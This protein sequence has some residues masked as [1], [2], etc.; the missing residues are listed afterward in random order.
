MHNQKCDHKDIEEIAARIAY[1][2]EERRIDYT[3]FS[4][5]SMKALGDKTAPNSDLTFKGDVAL[6][7]RAFQYVHVSSLVWAKKYLDEETFKEFV[8]A[9]GGML[10]GDD[11]QNSMPYIKEYTK[12]KQENVGD[13]FN[14]QFV[15][16]SEDIAVGLTK[17]PSGMILAPMVSAGVLD[18]YWMSLGVAA[19]EFGD[20]ETYSMISDIMS[21]KYKG[22]L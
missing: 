12:A 19:F 17:S 18:F 8:K 20:K 22:G 9:L 6:I 1:G 2:L 11:L 5:L 16:F 7:I 21:Q 14:K 13:N 3:K 10:I 4:I 15:R